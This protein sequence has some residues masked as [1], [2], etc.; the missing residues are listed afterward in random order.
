MKS[1]GTVITDEAKFES[2]AERLESLLK[3][4]LALARKGNIAEM[5]VLAKKAH[6]LVEQI[7][8]SE[9]L[10]KPQFKQRRERLEQIYGDLCLALS[11]QMND[12]SQALGRIHK[13][14][15]IMMLYRDNI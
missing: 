4:Q 2:T 8:G 5:E 9:F 11:L 6:D 3:R 12:V 7:S 10:A 14:K 13:G 1:V 15:R